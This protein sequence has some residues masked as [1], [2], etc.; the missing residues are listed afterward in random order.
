MIDIDVEVNSSSVACNAVVCGGERSET[1]GER[2]E[3][4]I[5]KDFDEEGERRDIIVISPESSS[6]SGVR[7]SGFGDENEEN[8]D[9]DTEEKEKKRK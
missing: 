1:A 9:G 3:T 8:D 4:V 5:S 6:S 7:V 2:V